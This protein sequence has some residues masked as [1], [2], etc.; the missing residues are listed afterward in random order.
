MLSVNHLSVYYMNPVPAEIHAWVSRQRVS[1]LTVVQQ[2]PRCERS[3]SV[4]ECGGRI[5]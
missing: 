5:K 1:L 4:C 2:T 3:A